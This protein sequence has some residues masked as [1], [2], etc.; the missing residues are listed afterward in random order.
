MIKEAKARPVSEILGSAK[1]LVI[2]P[3]QRDYK[4]TPKQVKQL[5]QD[6]CDEVRWEA[7]AFNPYYVGAVVTCPL[8]NPREDF[9][10]LDGQQRLT[11]ISIILA[12]LRRILKHKLNSRRELNVT[13]LLYSGSVHPQTKIELHEPSDKDGD[14]VVF[15]DILLTDTEELALEE[16]NKKRKGRA[17]HGVRPHLLASA[18]DNGRKGRI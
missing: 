8:D 3:F 2:P 18:P 5:I 6:V 15:R 11:T 14:Q 10:V 12:T 7:N 17:E 4:W 9:E 16:A 1:R 13:S